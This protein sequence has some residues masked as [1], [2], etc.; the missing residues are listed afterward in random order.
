[1][2]ARCRRDSN[3][4][5]RQRENSDLDG[6]SSLEGIPSVASSSMVLMGGGGRPSSCWPGT[7]PTCNAAYQSAGIDTTRKGRS[8][9]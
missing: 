6:V 3:S 8:P 1:M 9:G 7:A 2:A 5:E 4:I